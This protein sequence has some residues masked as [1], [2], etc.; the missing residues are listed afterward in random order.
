LSEEKDLPLPNLSLTNLMQVVDK[1][2]SFD[3]L[4]DDN[5]QAGISPTR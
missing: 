1:G 3:S 5:S 4:E 2:R